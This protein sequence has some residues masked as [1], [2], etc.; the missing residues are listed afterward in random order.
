MSLPVFFSQIVGHQTALRLL[1]RAVVTGDVAHAYL[2]TGMAGV[3]KHSVA[4]A[5]A[6]ALACL[7]PTPEGE[8]CGEC[9]SC[10]RLL[11]ESHPEIHTIAPYSEQTLIWQLWDG[12]SVPREAKAHQVGVIGRTINF[13]P[14]FGRRIVYILTR[15]ETLTEAAANS[16]L[17][18]AEEP[19]PY[20]V[21]LLLAPMPE[22]VI[23][24]IRSRCQ[25]VPLHPVDT[26]T[27]SE[28]LV[29]QH[30]VDPQLAHRCALMAQGCPGRAWSLATQPQAL[31]LWDA[32]ADLAYAITESPSPAP[33]L[34]LAERLRS[35]AT[36]DISEEGDPSIEAAGK[37]KTPTRGALLLAMDALCAWFRDALWIACGGDPSGITY[38]GDAER[39]HRAAG[40]LGVQGLMRAL[41]TVLD[42]RRAVEGNANVQL[43]TEV[44]MMR[45]LAP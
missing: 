16:L 12:H 41:D 17:K 42:I 24:T 6:A 8:A 25:W 1:R 43:A 14:T 11:S 33:A 35:L 45:L 23:E 7:H 9:E 38:Q 29:V 22:D 28:W 31:K 34:Q 18:T 20:V 2:L 10:R 4:H 3:G 19:P 30:N 37:G 40:S 39:L 36:V 13:A 21:F 26:D 5:F 27:I 15:A 44:L 32:L